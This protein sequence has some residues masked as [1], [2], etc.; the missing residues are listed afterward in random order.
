[1]SH[2]PWK[3]VNGSCCPFCLWNLYVQALIARVAREVEEISGVDL[4]QLINPAKVS[5]CLLQMKFVV[6]GD[7]GALEPCLMSFDVQAI[8]HTQMVRQ[9]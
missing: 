3:A 8:L 4:E 5:S 7:H 6:E 1:M 9:W 2:E